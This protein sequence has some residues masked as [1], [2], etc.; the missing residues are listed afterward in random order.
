MGKKSIIIISSSQRLLIG[1]LSGL[2]FLAAHADQIKTNN[3]SN[4]E[5]GSSWTGGIAPTGTE[6]AIWNATVATSANCTNNL[7]SAAIWGGIVISNPAAPVYIAGNTTLTLSNGI[8]L[9]NATVNLTVDCS[10]LNLGAN[11]ILSLIHI[12]EPTRLGMISY[13]VFC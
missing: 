12:S 4:L 3:L 9:A 8:N 13:A 1:W 10:T 7:G 2:V 5:L 6:N 11:Q